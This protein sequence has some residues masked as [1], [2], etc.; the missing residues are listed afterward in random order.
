MAAD[1]PQQ[2][3]PGG[4]AANEAERAFKTPNGDGQLRRSLRWLTYAASGVQPLGVVE[5]TGALGH[6]FLEGYN[7]P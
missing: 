3:R 4:D 6:L 2:E 7:R 1:D 5:P